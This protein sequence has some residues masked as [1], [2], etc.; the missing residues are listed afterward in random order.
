[1]KLQSIQVLRGFAA[2]LVAMTHLVSFEREAIKENGLSE[3]SLTGGLW[4]NGFAGV[5][6]FFVISGFIMVYVAANRET[7]VRSVADFWLA[8]AFR[9]FPLWWLFSAAMAVIFLY[10]HSTPYHPVE[11]EKTDASAFA[12]VLKSTFLIPQEGLPILGVG[13]TLIHEMYFYVLFGLMLLLPQKYLPSLMFGWLL[14]I[15]ICYML[16]LSS[17]NPDSLLHVATYPMTAE[18]ILGALAGIAFLR[19]GSRFAFGIMTVGSVG[20][21]LALVFF[22]NSDDPSAGIWA[23]L[24]WGRVIFFG[25]PAVALVYGLATIERA[26]NI[27]FPKWMVKLGDE[28][29]AL[30][31]CHTIVFIAVMRVL[32][33]VSRLSAEL[34]WVNTIQSVFMVGAPGALDNLVFAV[35]CLGCAVIVA[36][37]SYRF[38]E[39]PSLKWLSK[40]RKRAIGIHK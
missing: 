8:R 26:K 7:G 32:F 35:L 1:M 2:F 20:F 13:W 21:L 36:K 6:L 28:S 31:L 4:E 27:S 10:V 29:F 3:Q 40:L 38:F 9:I 25:L 12:Y 11:F 23:T 14:L 18:F 16:G 37:L 33:E 39:R 30:Y 5:D 34:S 24:E 15:L 17:T 22:K 19:R